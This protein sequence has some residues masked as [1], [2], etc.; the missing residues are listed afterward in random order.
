MPVGCAVRPSRTAIIP[1]MHTAPTDDLSRGLVIYRA[2]RLEALLDPLL[3]LLESVPP[4]HVLAP[5]TVIAA[6]P[7]MRHWLAGA[8]ARKRG[9]GG[10]VANL[11]ISLP[12]SWLDELALAVLDSAAVALAPFRRDRL[13][14]RIHELLPGI[15]DPQVRAYL[16]GGDAAR[17]RYQD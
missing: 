8:L 5:Q 9:P 1:T 6:H 10:I 7:G 2:S 11:R 17:R 12:S 3:T 15:D 16:A 14:W 13:R 4:A